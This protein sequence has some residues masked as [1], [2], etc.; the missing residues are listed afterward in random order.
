[1][2]LPIYQ[3][4]AFASEVFRGNPAAVVPY[5]E[6]LS[7]ELMQS[8]AMENNL[9]E[10]AF[11]Q[12][13]GPGHYRI[14]WF[15]PAVEVDLCGH[16]T[17]AAAWV[18]INELEPGLVRVLFDSGVGRLEVDARDGRLIL[19][20]PSRPPAPI[21]IEPALVEETLGLIMGPE[22]QAR[23][24]AAAIARSRDFETRAFMRRAR[25]VWADVVRRGRT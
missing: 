19:D 12:A 10:T 17:L 18:V 3:V 5:A 9:S 6:P 7:T 21:G 22:L 2:K 15:T 20:F 23:M 1:M 14:R 25:E 8:I 16:A 24:A 11:I 13:S 4:D